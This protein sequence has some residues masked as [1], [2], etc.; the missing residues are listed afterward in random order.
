VPPR[1]F[2]ARPSSG[3]P[4]AASGAPAPVTAVLDAFV[5][6]SDHLAPTEW[7]VGFDDLGRLAAQPLT[8]EAL[9]ASARAQ[10]SFH[11]VAGGSRRAVRASELH[12]FEIQLVEQAAASPGFDDPVHLYGTLLGPLGVGG[13]AVEGQLT[14]TRADVLDAAIAGAKHAFRYGGDGSA[15][16]FQ[17]LLPADRLEELAQGRGLVLAYPVLSGD[18]H[19]TVP[20]N[21]FFFNQILYDVIVGLW[22]DVEAEAPPPRR[23]PQ[24]VPVPNRALLEQ[25]LQS[26]GFVIEGDRAVRKRKGLLGSVLDA[27]V[28]EGRTLP[29]EGQSDDYVKLAAEALAAIPGWPSP[30]ARA[31]RACLGP[32]PGGMAAPPPPRHILPPSPPP[33]P[34][35]RTGP[36]AWMEDFIAARARPGA[37]PPVVTRAP[38]WMSDFVAPAAAPPEGHAKEAAEQAEQ[39][40]APARPA[41]MKD[42]DS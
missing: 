5:L 12:L 38:A 37:P 28:E 27:L 39:P 41:W 3:S 11:E 21:E 14:V 10:L 24:D 36:P 29:P 23:R 35:R 22:A 30:R 19:A 2:A 40:E 15:R 17:L 9:P 25:R 4:A 7:V 1:Y 8:A 42:F 13:A 34:Q 6:E 33:P 32:A 26:E 31:L 16:A 20:G 18:L